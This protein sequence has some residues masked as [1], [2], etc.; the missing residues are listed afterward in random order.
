MPEETATATTEETPVTETATAPN[1]VTVDLG[2]DAAK[3]TTETTP[4]P[5]PTAEATTPETAAGDEGATEPAPVQE[6]EAKKEP[7]AQEP[8]PEATEPEFD[9]TLLREAR[10]WGFTD[11]D[12]KAFEHPDKLRAAMTALDRKVVASLQTPS[13]PQQPTA[14]VPPSPQTAPREVPPPEFKFQLDPE[15]FDEALIGQLN[16]MNTHYQQHVTNMQQALGFLANEFQRETGLGKVQRFDGYVSSLGD[17]YES[18]VGKGTVEEIDPN[19]TAF[20]N[21]NRV[22]LAMDALRNGYL[23]NNRPVPGERELFRRALRMEMGDQLASI[24]RKKLNGEVQRKRK[25]VVHR[26]TQRKSKAGTP[27]Q[28]AVEDVKAIVRDRGINM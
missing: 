18:L 21:R 9:D 22:F 15:N 2:F 24:E 1:D 7:E 13:A 10:E 26:P 19:S 11:A 12:A 3:P 14:Q 5:Q 16:A 20:V 8:E 4:E 23:Q 28:A 25:Q 27:L 6:P 17:E